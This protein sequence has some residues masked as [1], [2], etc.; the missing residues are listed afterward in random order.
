MNLHRFLPASLL[1]LGFPGPS[2]AQVILIDNL[3]QKSN[4]SVAMDT[5]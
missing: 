4:G 2:H 1:A 3:P 5:V